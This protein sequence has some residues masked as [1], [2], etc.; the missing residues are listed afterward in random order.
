[1]GAIHRA[2]AA[3]INKGAGFSLAPLFFAFMRERNSGS[4][5][6][7]LGALFNNGVVQMAHDWNAENGG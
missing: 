6:P 2:P 5:A 7:V 4:K 3:V 1:M